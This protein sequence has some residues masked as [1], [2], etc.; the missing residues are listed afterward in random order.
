MTAMTDT[1][2]HDTTSSRTTPSPSAALSPRPLRKLLVANRGEIALRVMRTAGRLGIATVAVYSAA[3]RDALHVRQADE[4]VHIGDAPPAASYLNIDA[5]LQAARAT[6]A[7]AVHPGYGFLSENAGFAQACADAGLVFV[8]PSAAA[9][10][11]MGDK[12][13][14]KRFMRQAGL[15]CVPGYD[16]DAQDDA[17]LAAEAAIVGFPAIVKATGG[18]GGR[19]MRVAESAEG[20]A[21]ALASARSEAR[22]AF[23]NDRMLIERLVRRPRHVEIQVLV[24]RYGSGVHFGERDCSVQR[25]HQKVIEEAPAPGVS[26]AL[27]ERLGAAAVAAA[28][29]LGYEGV[30]TFEFLLEED[31]GF[32]FMEMNTRLQVE[33]P[34]TEYVAGTDLVEW[35]LRV[36][37]GEPLGIGQADVRL[38]GHAIEVRLCAEDE[39][40]GFLP[41]SG[42]IDLWRA[43][44]GLRVE[45]AVR[46][47][48]EVSP[49]YDSMFAKLIAGGTTRE[50]ARQALVAGLRRTVC[51]G[52]RSNREALI[53][54]LEHPA[55]VAG[56]VDTGFLQ[57]H[58]DALMRAPGAAPADAVALAAAVLVAQGRPAAAGA[59]PSTVL[60]RDAAGNAHTVSVAPGAAG[61]VVTGAWGSTTLALQHEADGAIRFSRD[62]VEASGF[63]LALQDRV[64]VQI[65]G[66]AESF[67]DITYRPARAAGAADDSRV[68]AMS[69]GRVARVFV[70]PGEAVQAGAALLTVEAMKMEHVHLAA[71]AGTVRTV[72]VEEGALVQTGKVL[73]E[74]DPAA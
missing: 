24:D 18:G 10:A 26:V 45:T 74:L 11:A 22:N 47:G 72:L 32:F 63:A 21:A 34:V 44:Q 40:Q 67:E 53:R 9:I 71:A 2:M 8:G 55:F 14:A 27:R 36:A 59:W 73:V 70:A 69:N 3:D 19:G 12:A 54:F 25:R 7:D 31:G 68:R 28:V 41:Q 23:G 62:G 20:F 13:E 15:P 5:I 37:R 42:R 65:D 58:H 4:A 43:P 57:H 48:S 38:A 61:F 49:Y 51:F 6:G 60:L 64:H 16:G 33:H 35:Q 29:R 50:D 39:T 56:G 46:T 66:R 1:G 17:T 52:L 30:G